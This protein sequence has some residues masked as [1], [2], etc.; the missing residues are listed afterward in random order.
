VRKCGLFRARLPHLLSCCCCLDVVVVFFCSSL[1]ELTGLLMHFRNY[2]FRP[3]QHWCHTVS[4]FSI[5]NWIAFVPNGPTSK[6][7]DICSKWNRNISQ[8]TTMAK[9]SKPLDDLNAKS[10]AGCQRWSRFAGQ[11]GG[12]AK[13]EAIL[14]HRR[15]FCLATR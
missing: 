8:E 14:P 13:V 15:F 7:V 1:T 4:Y 10:E 3:T 5:T 11:N 6:D 2:W 9:E 12:L